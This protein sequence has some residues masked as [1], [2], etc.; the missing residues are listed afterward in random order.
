MI[1]V[2]TYCRNKTD[3]TQ[4]HPFK[5]DTIAFKVN[6]KAFALMP[7]D[8]NDARI[9]LK[10]DPGRALELREAYPEITPGYHMNK[11]HW[12][13]LDLHGKL[14]DD[15]VRELIDHSYDLIVK[16]KH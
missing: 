6:G 13:T 7:H 1:D 10:C 11:E 2:I 12:N 5:T 8:G 16:N 14:P 9:T 15:L 4:E 3:A